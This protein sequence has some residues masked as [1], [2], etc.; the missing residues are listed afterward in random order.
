MKSIE[1]WLNKHNIS[2]V[3]C[4]VA[5]MAG[6]TRGKL[7][8]VNDFIGESPKLSEGML[9]QTITGNYCD[10]HDDFVSPEDSD[11]LLTAVPKSIRLVPWAKRATAQV[12][13]DCYT[14]EGEPHY[15]SSRNVLKSVLA[16]YKAL[17]LKAVIAPE[18]E[19][20]LIEKNS[21]SSKALTSPLGASGRSTS[22]KQPLGMDALYEF[23][24]FINTLY[25]YCDQQE[26]AVGT[27]SHE[28]GTAQMEINFNHGDP[29]DL[30]DQVFMFKRTLKHAALKQGMYATFMA[31]PMADQ[32]GSSMH[33]HQSLI[34]LES[35]TNAFCTA[36]GDKTDTF[37]HYLAG[38]QKYTPKLI[39]FYAP[40]VNSY[41]RFTNY[42]NAPSNLCWGYDN[43]TVAFRVPDSKPEATRIE[44]RF[45]GIDSNPY[46]A[47][48]ASLASG[49]AGIKN[50]LSPTAPFKGCVD[51]AEVKIATSLEKALDNLM[52]MGDFGTIISAEFIHAYRSV[53]LNELAEYNSVITAWER[54]N[55]LSN[56]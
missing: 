42:L 38:L 44:N 28:S 7:I 33:I 39:S 47:I 56:V 8:R 41:R 53:K 29:L 19:F 21:D 49:L 6:M 40:N 4:L 34:D 51:N 55:L 54:E 10:E 37:M 5:D 46:L 11:M 25:E 15:L 30:A 48:A 27:L 24:S 35:G 50:K 12:I 22:I 17:G 3:E 52:D 23:E 18:V 31:K 9:L 26:L 45:S 1:Q 13:H 43:R 32:P 36:T 14:P 20:Y 16:E 2:D